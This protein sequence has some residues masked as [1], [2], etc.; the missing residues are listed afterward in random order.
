MRKQHTGFRQCIL[1]VG[2][3]A[4]DHR[5]AG[6]K[7]TDVGIQSSRRVVTDRKVRKGREIHKMS[8]DHQRDNQ[9]LTENKGKETSPTT[10][11]P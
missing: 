1:Y 6:E 10:R 8:S 9:D 11:E 2:V 3:Q 5:H 7:L 4:G